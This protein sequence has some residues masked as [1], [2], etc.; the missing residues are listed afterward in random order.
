MGTI[1]ISHIGT[2]DFPAL[3][4]LQTLKQI[5]HSKFI[6]TYSSR[7]SMPSLNVPRIE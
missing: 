7:T 1:G 6:F 3:I 5:F 2:S 4:Y